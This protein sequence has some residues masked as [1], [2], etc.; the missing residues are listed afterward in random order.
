MTFTIRARLTLLYSG[1]LALVLLFVALATYSTVARLSN[2][3]I[4][5]SLNQAARQYMA[6]LRVA[7]ARLRLP[8]EEALV[9]ASERVRFRDTRILVYDTSGRLVAASRVAP[10]ALMRGADVFA[11]QA[12]APELMD[13]ARNT[14]AS[15]AT[16]KLSDGGAVRALVVPVRGPLAA[17]RIVVLGSMRREQ[18]LLEDLRH[19]FQIALPLALL[20]ASLAGYL[21]AR[22]S[23][24]PVRVMAARAE[25][26]S[27]ANLHERLPVGAQKDELA[28]LARVFN[29]LLARLEQSFE[30]QRQFMADAAHELRTPLAVIRSEA[31]VALSR[32]SRSEPEYRDSL[33]AVEDESKRLTRIVEDLFTMAR[34]DAG[35]HAIRL[36]P[37]YLKDVLDDVARA[38]RTLAAERSITV[39]VD[40]PEEMPTRGDEPLLRR[41]LLNLVDN[42]VK[43]TPKDGVVRLRARRQNDTYVIDVENTGEPI[44]EAAQQRIFDRFFRAHAER[45]VA[46]KGGAGLGLPIARWIARAHGGDLRLDRS[47]SGVTRFTVMLPASSTTGSA[48]ANPR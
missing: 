43:H 39:E 16:L 31:E 22:H 3:S 37:L 12:D 14:S 13:L 10:G 20:V 41:M 40:A 4:N 2:V 7:S 30:Q 44:P 15:G 38:F 21:L 45:G 8:P 34:A 26:I 23:L 47:D 36:E 27:S 35:Q 5:A 29:E 6:T 19:S 18:E 46:D 24:A 48:A 1:V 33:E 32:A 9:A 42:A 11:V 25:Q 28:E 17:Y